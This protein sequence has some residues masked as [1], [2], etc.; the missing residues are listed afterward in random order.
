M[1]GPVRPSWG[2][3]RPVRVAYTLE[4]CWHDVP[5]GT[6]VAALRIARAPDPRLRRSSW[7]ASPAGTAG[8]RPSRGAR[9]SRWPRSRS[10]GPG[11]TRAGCGSDGRRSSARRDPSTSCHATA[12]VPAPTR[13]PLVVTVHD[14]AFVHDPELVH[15]AR[16][17][18][19]APQPRTH[20]APRRH[21]G[22]PERGDDGRPRGRRHR[23]RP[24]P[25]RAARGR[26]DRRRRPTTSRPG[27]QHVTTCPPRFVLFVGT[28]EPR[29]NLERLALAV[30]RLD[31]PLP[32]VDRRRRRLGWRRRRRRSASVD[33]RFLGFVGERRPGRAL[34]G[35]LGVRLPERVGGVRAAGRRGD[36]AGH[37]GRHEPRDRR[38]RR[39]PAG[40]RSSSTRSTST[41]SHAV[42]RPRSATAT[43]CAAA[44]LA[45]AARAH[46][47]G[48]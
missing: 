42:S 10:P 25:A 48:R 18:R 19:D 13:A 30:A 45:R 28:I 5:G 47:G 12:L 24:A 40:P 16:R 46:L 8:H 23:S 26:L 2:G 7:S 44:G 6:A 36:G 33:A 35:G 32:L 31:E 27:P 22:V 29:K 4:Q 11:C 9:R 3:A 15:P 43:G 20:P 38:P 17:A 41:T 37:A 34:R 39:S 14:L 21:R 1:L